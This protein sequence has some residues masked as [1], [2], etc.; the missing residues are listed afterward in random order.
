MR[1]GPLSSFTLS[2]CYLSLY[3]FIVSHNHL[4]DYCECGLF[5]VVK[6]SCIHT[7]CLH[8]VS[9]VVKL[10]FSAVLFLTRVL[11]CVVVFRLSDYHI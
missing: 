8:L 5:G 10:Y 4:G 2:V 11:L 9:D 3:V 6:T 7:H 1:K